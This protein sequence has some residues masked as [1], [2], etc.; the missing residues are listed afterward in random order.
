MHI[1]SV[2][3]GT[4]DATE[5]SGTKYKMKNGVLRN[6]FPLGQSNEFDG[7]HAEISVDEGVL[8]IVLSRVG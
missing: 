1:H 8:M 7:D 2:C 5:T 6:S 3:S 4:N